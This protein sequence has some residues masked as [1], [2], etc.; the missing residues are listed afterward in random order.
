MSDKTVFENWKQK[1][2]NCLLDNQSLILEFDLSERQIGK[3]IKSTS[4]GITLFCGFS[5]LILETLGNCLLF[6]IVWYEKFGMDSKKRT[7]TNQLL[8]RMIIARIFFNILFMPTYFG[9][10]LLFPSE[11]RILRF[12]FFIFS[13]I[14]CPNTC[15]IIFDYRWIRISHCWFWFL[16]YHHTFFSN[17]GW[18]GDSQDSLLVQIFYHC[19]NGWIFPYKF[20]KPIQRYDKSWICNNKSLIG[21]T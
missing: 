7:I 1:Y 2:S 5:L 9:S 17:N 6:F 21:W 11:F 14:I 13:K 4:L 8:S 20:H 10:L 16:S 3:K 19:C 18:N 15:L 12:I